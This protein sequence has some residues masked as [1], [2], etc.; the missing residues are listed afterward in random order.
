MRALFPVRFQMR[1]LKRKMQE[2]GFLHGTQ[3]VNPEATQKEIDAQFQVYQENVRHSA[4]GVIA[5]LEA[6]I[7][8]LEMRQRDASAHWDKMRGATGG[9]PPHVAP[10]LL[11]SVL[12]LLALVGEIILLA[13]VLDG[14]GIADPI[15]QQ[16][17][18][19]ALVIVIAGLFHMAIRRLKQKKGDEILEV[20]VKV[21]SESLTDQI[22]SVGITGFLMLMAFALVI[23]L[24]WW[25]AEEMTFAADLVGGE[26]GS[27]LNENP[28]LTRVCIV[29]LT[30]G[31]PLFAAATSDWSLS[32]LRIAW[33][34]RKSER[35]FKR[36]GKQ[37]AKSRKAHGAAE[38]K[39]ERKVASLVEQKK[40]VEQAYLQNVEYGRVVGAKQSPLWQAV[41]KIVAVTTLILAFCLLID[42]MLSEYLDS[43][44]MRILVYVL[45][46][47]GIGGSYAARAIKA[48]D[49][50]T[51]RQLMRNRA[52]KWSFRE[53]TETRKNTNQREV[54]TMV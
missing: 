24:G 48:W 14:F 34:W 50:P 15:K 39:R 46:T 7:D 9:R 13:P 54:H 25:R 42:P 11:G 37:L 6:R 32:H 26:L 12:V 18:A 43:L 10:P 45:I 28:S 40:E 27:F 53:T 29:L 23:T 30:A 33:E 41:L 1:V 2:L 22:G 44:L 35:R 19:T 31:L 20:E 21:A 3:N 16:G 51:A 38:E 5:K 47:T 52:I 17:A 49:R 36:Y 4:A 8:T